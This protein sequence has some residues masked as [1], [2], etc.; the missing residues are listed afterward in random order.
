MSI[1]GACRYSVLAFRTLHQN[2][3]FP[4]LMLV[5]TLVHLQMSAAR[6]LRFPSLFLLIVVAFSSPALTNVIPSPTDLILQS[7]NISTTLSKP[8]GRWA[9]YRSPDFSV[10]RAS[11]ADC[12]AVLRKVPEDYELPW[13]RSA[14]SVYGLLSL[15]TYMIHFTYF[16]TLERLSQH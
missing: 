12:L 9:C 8:I 14:G 5:N 16:S 4:L 11:Y 1:F 7:L 6:M 15:E 3:D 10:R 2:S 13:K